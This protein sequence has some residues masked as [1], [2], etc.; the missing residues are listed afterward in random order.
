MTAAAAGGGDAADSST[1]TAT[2]SPSLTCTGSGSAYGGW[3]R[4][5]ESMTR[6]LNTRRF[7]GVRMRTPLLACLQKGQDEVEE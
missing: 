1:A 4:V 6:T 7:N 3:V 5:L 2:T